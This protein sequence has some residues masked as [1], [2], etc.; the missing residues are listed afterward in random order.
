MG[1][2]TQ[3]Q[4]LIMEEKQR[5]IELPHITVLPVFMGLIAIVGMLLARNLILQNWKIFAW[6]WGVGVLIAI[7]VKATRIL[8]AK[9]ANCIRRNTGSIEEESKE[10][11]SRNLV[12]FGFVTTCY[13]S[14]LLAMK[15]LNE[16]Y[17]QLLGLD[18]SWHVTDVGLAVAEKRVSIVLGHTGGQV[19][20][21]SCGQSCGI[22]DH[23]PARSWRHLDTMQFETVLTARIPRCRCADC[24]VKT[25]A[26]P[27]AEKH[28]RFTLLFEAFAIE[29]LQACST[30]HGACQLLGVGWDA[31]HQLMRRAVTRGLARRDRAPIARVGL[32]EKSFRRRHRYVTLLNDLDTARVLDV[33]EGRDQ[34]AVDTVW[35]TLSDEQRDHVQAASIDM[36]HPYIASIQAYL[37]QAQI[38]H[39]KFHISQHLNK[40]VDQVRRQEHKALMKAGDERLKGTRQLWLYNPD[41]LSEK[42]WLQLK[43]LKELD[44]KTARAWAIKE[45]FAWFWEY[46]YAGAARTFFTHWY[47]W[48]VRSQLPPVRA[49]AKMLKTHLANILTYFRHRITNAVSE[50]L[51]SRIQSIK[52]AARGFRSFANYRT[53]IL[54]FCGKL[55]LA[56]SKRCH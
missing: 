4:N 55:D 21:P 41:H 53:R 8:Y 31:A 36:W 15:T 38:V 14:I 17:S 5:L 33:V 22:A 1:E 20:C 13:A 10:G 49:V 19:S 43:P 51:N 18:P 47:N 16:H 12:A 3:E 30:I 2:G 6:L 40:A 9:F 48:A 50:G 32:D 24:G 29:V 27:W 28:S 23:A 11:S 42:R 37:P 7:A 35:S 39:D 46:R 34:A 44:L 25:I 26:V 52:T 56:P 45:H 54:F